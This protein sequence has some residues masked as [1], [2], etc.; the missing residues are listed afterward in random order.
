MSW[1]PEVI[2][3]AGY[4]VSQDAWCKAFDKLFN[5]DNDNLPSEWEDLFICGDPVSDNPNT[6]FFGKII[7]SMDD[8]TDP[9]ALSAILASY[10][11]IKEVCEAYVALFEG[12]P[13]TFEKWLLTRWS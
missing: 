10:S 8:H 13:P 5:S 11:V 1:T 3:V 9:I 6:Y 4:K 2:V 12:K 7:L